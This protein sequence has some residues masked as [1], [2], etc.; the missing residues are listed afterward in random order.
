MEGI[1]DG[2]AI[3][4]VFNKNKEVQNEIK[5]IVLKEPV[6][7]IELDET[8]VEIGKNQKYIIYATVSP[9]TAT[10]KNVIW[11]SNDENILS[12]DE[13]GIIKT[14]EVGRTSVIAITDNGDKQVECVF[15]IVNNPKVNKKLYAKSENAIRN[16]PNKNFNLLGTTKK[17][18]EV[19]LLC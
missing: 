14:K 5:I 4:N 1:K 7:K 18:E 17:N 12:I 15:N 16:G 8:S 13:N 19:E 9:E 3:I 2:E 10:Y 11:K 6:E